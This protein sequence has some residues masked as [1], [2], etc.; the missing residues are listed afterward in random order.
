[1]TDSYVK[2]FDDNRN[3]IS[4][5][6]LEGDDERTDWRRG[7]GV[8]ARVWESMGK[9]QERG[10]MTGASITV[11]SGNMR[12]VT[13]SEYVAK[14]RERGDG[15]IFYVE[16]V[17]LQCGT[18]D[19]VLSMEE[20]EE[21]RDRTDVLRADKKNSSLVFL[22]FPGDEEAMGGCLAS[23]R[24]FSISMS[25]APPSPARSLRSR[26]RTFRKR[27]FSGPFARRSSRRCRK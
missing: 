6:S 20:L 1:M 4:V 13:D 25:K 19:M 27:A 21:M 5:F 18:E 22:S 14:L 12:D 16:F 9:L 17:Q 10:I 2:L 7:E 15:V 24:G 8:A 3:L 23:G 26:S 11:T